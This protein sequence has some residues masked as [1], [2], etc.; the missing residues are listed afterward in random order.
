MMEGEGS[1]E[2]S[3]GINT[4]WTVPYCT[5]QYRNTVCFV[6]IITVVIY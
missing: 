4:Y 2:S 3:Y 6:Y 1:L 5:K